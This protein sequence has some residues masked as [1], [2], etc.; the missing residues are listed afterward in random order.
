MGK[1]DKKFVYSRLLLISYCH[2]LLI[3]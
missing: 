3:S 1:L 2:L